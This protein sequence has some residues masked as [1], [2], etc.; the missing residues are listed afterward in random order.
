MYESDDYGSFVAAGMDL[1][2][3]K[4][5]DSGIRTLR[6]RFSVVVLAILVTADV[7]ASRVALP[8][9]QAGVIPRQG[10]LT[11]RRDGTLPHAGTVVA[12]FSASETSLSS[13]M[14]LSRRKCRPSAERVSSTAKRENRKQHH[15]LWAGPR[16]RFGL[17]GLLNLLSGIDGAR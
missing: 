5:D 12:P 1:A 9:D 14:R 8:V 4:M 15:R 6:N 10:A 7:T 3:V 13:P 16:G 11:A 17:G 2:F